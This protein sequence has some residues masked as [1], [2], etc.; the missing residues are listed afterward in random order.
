[1]SRDVTWFVRRMAHLN[2]NFNLSQNLFSAEY[3]TYSFMILFKFTI[4]LC[5]YSDERDFK[6]GRI[7]SRRLP[8]ETARNLKNSGDI[9]LIIVRPWAAVGCEA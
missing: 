6:I 9:P 4:S 1:M 8:R 5:A 2:T 7:K 3:I